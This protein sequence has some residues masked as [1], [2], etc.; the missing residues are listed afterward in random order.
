MDV[1]ELEN[2]QT[3]IG[4][5]AVGAGSTKSGR[6]VV[7]FYFGGSVAATIGG[8]SF[9][10]TDVPLRIEAPSGSVLDSIPFN[11]S[12]GTLRVIQVG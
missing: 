9:A 7:I 3:E 8:S 4:D 5:H 2:L 10:S 12:A 6:A 1:G 11:V